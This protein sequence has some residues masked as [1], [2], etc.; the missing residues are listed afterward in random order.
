M[1]KYTSTSVLYVQA[2]WCDGRRMSRQGTCIHAPPKSVSGNIYITC[3]VVGTFGYK[4]RY[5][6]RFYLELLECPKSECASSC[7]ILENLND[8]LIYPFNSELSIT[9]GSFFAKKLRRLIDFSICLF[10]IT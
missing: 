3:T 5:N 1:C 9:S 4:Y 7:E 8:I 2:R 10:L 6:A